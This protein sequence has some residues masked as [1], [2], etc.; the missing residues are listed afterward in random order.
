MN[1]NTSKYIE[2]TFFFAS[3]PKGLACFSA[4]SGFPRCSF[5]MF[6]YDMG[7]F[8]DVDMTFYKD[9][10]QKDFLCNAIYAIFME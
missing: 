10:P 7:C 1:T 8:D 6:S 4:A 9:F 3:D 2:L 5:A